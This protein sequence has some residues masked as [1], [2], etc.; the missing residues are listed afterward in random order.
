MAAAFTVHEAMIAAG[1][2]DADNFDGNSS[3]ER[4]AEDIFDNDFVSC[5]DKSQTD[6]EADLKSFSGLTQV[7]G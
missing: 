5:M 1:V 2:N 3:A 6:V 7:Q 4:L